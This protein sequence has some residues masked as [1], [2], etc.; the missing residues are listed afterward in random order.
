[1]GI[2]EYIHTAPQAGAP[3]EAQKRVVVDRRAGVVG[4]RYATRSGYWRN[5]RVSRDLTLVEAEV[6]DE[7]S[8]GGLRLA[9]GETRRNLTTRGVALNDLVGETFWIGRVLARGTGLCEPCGHLEDVTGQGLLRPLVHRGGLRADVLTGGLVR[10]G[11]AIEPADEL[12]GVGVIVVR[13]R[14]VLLGRR[15][16]RHGRDT[17]SFPGGKAHGAESALECAT[18][19][20]REETGLVAR[21]GRVVAES[22]D[23]FPESRLAFRTRFV[24]VEDAAGEPRAREP[25]K[26]GAWN[27][28]SSDALPEP[29][30]RPVAS[31]ISD[32]FELTP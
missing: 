32:G 7:L 17:W 14:R 2:V 4:D 26:N 31:L 24:L 11:D 18:R 28:F 19:E 15:L 6:L 10:V 9:P 8:A 5:D 29:L 1:V 22:V 25:E 20:L 27:W 16:S 23:G 12:Q 13:N 21:A 3:M 30:F